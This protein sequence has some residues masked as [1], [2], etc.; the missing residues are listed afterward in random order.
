MGTATKEAQK[1]RSALDLYGGKDAVL[2]RIG[3]SI[4]SKLEKKLMEDALK[5]S[6]YIMIPFETFIEILEGN[7]RSV[8]YKFFEKLEG[9]LN[10]DRWDILGK[11]DLNDPKIRDYW[12]NQMTKNPMSA[13][14]GDNEDANIVLYVNVRVNGEL[15]RTC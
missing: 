1:E 6:R 11:P 3:S 12:K 15:A 2:K 4:K 7:Y 9:F 14:Y 10:L 13:P 5:F 8:N